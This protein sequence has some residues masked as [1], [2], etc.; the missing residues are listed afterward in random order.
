M[1]GSRDLL[2]ADVEIGLVYYYKI[3]TNLPSSPSELIFIPLLYQIVLKIM[4]LI[5]HL[6]LWSLKNQISWLPRSISKFY[7]IVGEIILIYFDVQLQP[8]PSFKMQI[9]PLM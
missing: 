6:M 4:F 3:Q 8:L 1:Q 5:Y 9:F 2:L 7:F